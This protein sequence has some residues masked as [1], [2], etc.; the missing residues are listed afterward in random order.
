MTQRPTLPRPSLCLCDHLPCSTDESLE[1][2]LN[3]AGS[4]RS[5][6]ARQQRLLHLLHHGIGVGG[7]QGVVFLLNEV[8]KCVASSGLSRP[9]GA[10]SCGLAQPLA[11]QSRSVQDDAIIETSG[12]FSNYVCMEQTFLS[13]TSEMPLGF[14]TSSSRESRRY[15]IRLVRRIICRYPSITRCDCATTWPEWRAPF[16]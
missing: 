6:V 11:K 15:A 16:N 14:S 7:S 13:S 12:I 9:L 4:G 5:R 1:I 2:R 10:V 8:S 3:C